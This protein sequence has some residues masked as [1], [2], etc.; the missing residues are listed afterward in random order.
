MKDHIFVT[1]TFTGIHHWKGASGKEAY[2]RHPHRH[3][4]NVKAAQAVTGDDRQIEF[5]NLKK[6]MLGYVRATWEDKQFEDSCE[7]IAREL[8]TT[9]NL[10]F[11][12][13]SEDGENGACIYAKE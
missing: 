10:L 12:E 5:I 7:M 4:F 9:F 13:V 1:F 6:N 8:V 3:Q 11:C 2:L